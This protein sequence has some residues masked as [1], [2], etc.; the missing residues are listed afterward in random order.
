[1]TTPVP[2]H[3]ITKIEATSGL[4]EIQEKART[5]IEEERKAFSEDA[6]NQGKSLPKADPMTNFLL[7]CAESGQIGDARVL[8]YFFRDRFR[9]DHASGRWYQWQGHYW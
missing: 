6:Q 7:D 4:E 3:C 1:M 8:I 9:H 5:R 2:P